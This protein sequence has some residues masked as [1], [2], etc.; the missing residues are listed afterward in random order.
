MLECPPQNKTTQTIDTFAP[1]GKLKMTVMG[2]TSK[3]KRAILLKRQP[4]GMVAANG[5]ASA[6][7]A[8]TLTFRI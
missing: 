8:K 1:A 7:V 3:F 4:E 6:K 5:K 2:A